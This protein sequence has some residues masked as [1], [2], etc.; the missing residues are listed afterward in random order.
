MS[1]FS[2][3]SAVRQGEHR[4]FRAPL[5]VNARSDG[6]FHG[7]HNRRDGIA[8]GPDVALRSPPRWR[9]GC[10]LPLSLLKSGCCRE[11]LD[12]SKF[13]EKLDRRPNLIEPSSE[14]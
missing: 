4:T 1:F 13:D 14:R 2:L 5:C 9:G 10:R 6:R 3:A 12:Y 11:Q 8:I 7:R